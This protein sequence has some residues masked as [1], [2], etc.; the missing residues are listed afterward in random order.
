MT[1]LDLVA[2]SALPAAGTLDGTEVVSMTQAGVSKKSTAAAIAALGGGGGG[3]TTEEV[4]DAVAAMLAEGTN[5]T[6]TYND[7]AGTLTIDAAGGGGGGGDWVLADEWDCASGLGDWTQ[8]FGSWSQQSGYWQNSAAAAALTFKPTAYSLGTIKLVAEFQNRSGGA[9]TSRLGIGRGDT[10]QSGSAANLV[11]WQPGCVH[12]FGGFSGAS[13]MNELDPQSGAG[14]TSVAADTWVTL[15]ATIVG[16]HVAGYVDT[17]PAGQ[18]FSGVDYRV[19][20]CV[21]IWAQD[22]GL[23][24]RNIKIYKSPLS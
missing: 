7:G 1:S 4:Q 20:N 3:L 17:V 13:V 11:T 8:S 21:A 12:A 5:I 14:V 24:V 19:S 16:T 22:G 10:T 18:C 6:L 9:G 23:R 2:A 15:Q